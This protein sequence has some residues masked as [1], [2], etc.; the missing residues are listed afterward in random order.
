V[1]AIGSQ[2]IFWVQK[3]VGDFVRLEKS[4]SRTKFG[5]SFQYYGKNFDNGII[6]G[7]FSS[8]LADHEGTFSLGKI[9]MRQCEGKFF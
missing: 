1:T 4:Y 6:R 7:V 5:S 3:N 9:E 2:P 8:L